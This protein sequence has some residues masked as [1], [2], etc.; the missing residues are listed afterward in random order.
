[1]S[2]AAGYPAFLVTRDLD[3]GFE[4][5]AEMTERSNALTSF[6]DRNTVATSGS[7]TTA[8]EPARIIPAKRFGRDLR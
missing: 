2:T 4:G 7:N 5:R 8:I 3:R 6:E 1:M